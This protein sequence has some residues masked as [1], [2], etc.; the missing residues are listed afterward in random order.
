MLVLVALLLAAP[1]TQAG[2]TE[3]DELEAALLVGEGWLGLGLK[4]STED[5]AKQLGYAEP[6]VLVDIVFADSPAEAAG[7]KTGDLILAVDD[8]RL[9]E[10]SE[11]V[12]IIRAK[13][14]GARV[15]LR[16]V[17]D[18]VEDVVEVSLGL[19]PG[20]N[21]LL[22]QH[23]LGKQAPELELEAIDDAFS[24]AQL[25]GRI[26]VLDFWATWCGPCHEA[27]RHLAHKSG[28]WP[29]EDVV[30]LG[31]SDEDCDTVRDFAATMET[32][33][34]LA[35]D[36]ERSSSRRFLVSAL[37][38]AFVIDREG[39]I[40]YVS[41]GAADFDALDQAVESLLP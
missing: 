28:Q 32:P 25:K 1:P 2:E 40:R 34:T 17:R 27:M 19:R 33:Y 3:L 5:E 29:K 16:R 35:C 30:I 38:T 9:S 22:R 31:V 39:V 18:G 7:F 4:R 10:T 12:A 13:A 36:L 37:P 20:A 8:S 15:S 14:P 41:I 21:E 6:K 11:L 26:V 23:L 24:S